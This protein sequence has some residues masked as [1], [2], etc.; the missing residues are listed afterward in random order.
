MAK[1]ID[2]ESAKAVLKSVFDTMHGLKA[3]ATPEVEHAIIDEALD[4]ISSDLFKKLTIDDLMYIEKHI[5][6]LMG[7]MKKDV[8]NAGSQIDYQ[9][10]VKMIMESSKS[11]DDGIMMAGILNSRAE[12]KEEVKIEV[13]ESGI[14][15]IP[16]KAH[17]LGIP[18]DAFLSRSSREYGYMVPVD[19]IM[20]FEMAARR[21]SGIA[22]YGG[23]VHT[24]GKIPEEAVFSDHY[25]VY[26]STMYIDHISV[27]SGVEMANIDIYMSKGKNNK[28]VI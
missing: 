1:E 21:D 8:G 18:R 10:L 9:N 4:F 2:I 22:N 13:D 25:Y 27:S 5:Y 3:D 20:F 15:E 23:N 11:L 24:F 17:Y 28:R 16:E 6:S 7:K 14:M 12:K 26:I 19:Y